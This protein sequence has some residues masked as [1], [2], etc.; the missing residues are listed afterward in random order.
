MGE[1][2]NP[3]IRKL[4]G[5]AQRME[6]SLKVG[7]NGL[8]PAF[9]ASLDEELSRHELVKVKFADLKERKK[10]LAPKLAK[11]TGARL[12]TLVGNVAVLFRRN[13]DPEKQVFRF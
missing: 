7:K 1:L 2:T 8:S 9:I 4:K 13:A 11:D 3:E 6:A 10:E 5:A 12:V